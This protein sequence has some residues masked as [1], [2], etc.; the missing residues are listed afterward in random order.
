[1]HPDC[2]LEWVIDATAPLASADTYLLT[3]R[4]HGWTPQQ[5][6]QWRYRTWM[7]FATIPGPATADGL[8]PRR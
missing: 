2:D 7:H 1:M 8:T 6:E 3:T 4:I 5:Y